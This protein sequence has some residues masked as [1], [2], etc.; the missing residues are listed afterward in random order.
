MA[1][2]VEWLH[3]DE[4]VAGGNRKS[5]F[6]GRNPEAKK[7]LG[8]QLFE[9]SST[10]AM[11]DFIYYYFSLPQDNSSFLYKILSD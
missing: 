5:V 10:E 6:G 11:I 9:T 8:E 4:A 3:A 2:P 7:G 1:F